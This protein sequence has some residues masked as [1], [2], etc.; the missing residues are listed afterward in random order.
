M[1]EKFNP[2]ESPAEASAWKKKQCKASKGSEKYKANEKRCM[3][4]K[5]TGRCT[6]V[7]K[8]FFN[9]HENRNI[10]KHCYRFLHIQFI[11]WI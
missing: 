8:C 6:M 1:I 11:K 7:G 3:K 5:D 10:C 4:K 9:S 2:S